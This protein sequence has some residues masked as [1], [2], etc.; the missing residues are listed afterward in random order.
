MIG[1]HIYDKKIIDYKDT[2]ANYTEVNNNY[3]FTISYHEQYSK[4]VI[5]SDKK[6]LIFVDGWIFNSKNY[7]NQAKF[8]L[9]LYKQFQEDFVYEL[10]GQF[11]I[12]ILDKL[13]GDFKIYNDIYSF[14]K[15]YF[16]IIKTNLIFS[17]D[18]EFISNHLATKTLNIEHIKKNLN[19]PRF[20]EIE[21]TFINEINQFSTSSIISSDL[22][23]V[24]YS[25][26]RVEKKFSKNLTTNPT[27]FLTTIKNRIISTHEN[28]EILLLLSGGLDSR[29]LLEI[30]K[31][32][33]IGVQTATYG[34]QHSD[35][36][37]IAKKVANKNKVNHFT[38]HLDG[39]DFI[40][41]SE[42]YIFQAG[43]LDIFVQST[44]YKFYE[45]F[46]GY[47]Q[48]DKLVI[49]TG[50]ALDMFL[51]GTQIDVNNGHE[52]A[53][54]NRVFSALSIRQSAHREFYEDRYSMYDYGIYF[55]M[56]NL[57]LE[58]IKN[59]KFYY[60]LCKLQIKNSFDVP[61]QSTMFDLNLHVDY[62]KDA[63]A[64]QLQKEKLVLKYYQDSGKA[65]YHNRYYSDFDMWIRDNN[66]WIELI[67]KLFIDR[68]S[69][70]SKYF[71]DNALI[72]ST[73]QE[74][75][76]GA[77]SHIR[78]IVKWVSLELFLIGISNEK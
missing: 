23:V 74:H 72:Q 14:R 1:I 48:N 50:F 8:I 45:N 75:K 25:Y 38:C 44:V 5:Y 36:V 66:K 7:E 6:Y 31:E 54:F 15:H 76:S 64:I 49:D 67:N 53:V 9:E 10:N 58:I 73:L 40:D 62:W 37:E 32:I 59:H 71:I 63:Q 42:K 2:H 68:E 29:F 26:E 69:Q 24:K 61:L 65:V 33:D 17:S 18:I 57:P 20:I 22:E 21:N 28:D 3:K 46:K 19:L 77:K 12:L 30:F 78:N 47:Y 52:Y 60:E 16:S 56:K 39:D 27:E 13:N 51:G 41:D 70:L 55:L 4:E 35:E 43:G 11:N 34:N